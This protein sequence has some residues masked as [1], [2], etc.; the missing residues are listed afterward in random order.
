MDIES[1]EREIINV[2]TDYSAET[3]KAVK[4]AVRKTANEARDL[5]KSS[6]KF[7]DKSGKYRDSIGVVKAYEDNFDLRVQVGAVKNGQYRLTHLLEY[8][9]ALRRG[10]RTLGKTG[11]FPHL[12]QAEEMVNE[13]LEKNIEKELEKIK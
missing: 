10:G 2:L 4:K 1:F 12:E 6:G 3:T 9:H 5:I 8:G 11:K 13:N 7:H